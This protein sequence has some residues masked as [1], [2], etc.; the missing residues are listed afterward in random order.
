MLSESKAGDLKRINWKWVKKYNVVINK[1][2]WSV[3]HGKNLEKN[4]QRFLIWYFVW[5]ALSSFKIKPTLFVSYNF[6]RPDI[7]I[8]IVSLSLVL[9]LSKVYFGSL[10]DIFLSLSGRVPPDSIKSIVSS[11][12]SSPSTSSSLSSFSLSFLRSDVKIKT[13]GTNYKF[14]DPSGA[15]LLSGRPSGHLTLSLRPSGHLTACLLKDMQCLLKDMQCLLKDMH[16]WVSW[17]LQGSH[18]LE[19]P[20]FNSRR[21]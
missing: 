6:S 8:W 18:S 21:S 16:S 10:M 15:Q 3:I 12:V 7:R 14:R 20:F 2:L 9:N 1:K 11:K 13:Y 19:Q 4:C 17:Q 5:F